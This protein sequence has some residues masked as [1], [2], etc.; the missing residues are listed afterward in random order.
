[1]ENDSLAGLRGAVDVARNR[2]LAALRKVQELAEQTPRVEA[3]V[4]KLS[5]SLG[6]GE[7]EV[8]VS[9]MEYDD[10]FLRLQAERDEER[11]SQEERDKRRFVWMQ[12]AIVTATISYVIL[13]AGLLVVAIAQLRAPPVTTTC[14]QAPR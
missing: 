7:V 6:T 12:V 4:I 11:R 10:V 13:T 9:R 3:E 8:E 14:P 5:G 2:Y 1:M